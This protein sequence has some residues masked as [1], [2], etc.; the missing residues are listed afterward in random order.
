MDNSTV[1]EHPIDVAWEIH[2]PI[3]F[4]IGASIYLAVLIF[5]INCVIKQYR[6][7]RCVVREEEGDTSFQIGG[8][9]R[10]MQDECAADSYAIHYWM[11]YE[12]IDR[13]AGTTL[14]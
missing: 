13:N 9:P 3:A 11:L 14:V 6:D 7:W 10:E 2:I 1:I 5:L 4:M 12:S 8:N